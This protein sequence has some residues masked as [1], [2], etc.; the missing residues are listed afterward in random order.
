M[1]ARTRAAFVTI[2]QT[3]RSDMLPEMLAGLDSRIAAMEFGALDGLD[4]TAVAAL[5]PKVGEHRLV[6]RLTDGSEAVVSKS[7]MRDRLA[8][9][10][11]ELDTRDFDLIVLLC[12]GHFEGLHPRTLF[13]ESQ[14]V[15]DHMTQALG[16]G[17]RRLGVLVPLEQQIAEF[18]RPAPGQEILFGA[19][20]PYSDRR[21][22]EAGAALR[23]ADL[24]VMHCMG[25]SEAMRRTVAESSSRPV[26][27]ARRLV[28]SA[29]AQLV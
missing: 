21:M 11:A 16:V 8:A 27:L 26:L 7:W 24:I 12:T 5:A 19:A 1:G 10:L 3:P 20:S 15:V 17:A 29:V 14:Q 2:G 25:Y 9:L 6:T 23:D 22:A 18:H 4:A 13:I 28:A